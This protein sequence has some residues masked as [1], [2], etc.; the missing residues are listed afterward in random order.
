[1]LTIIEKKSLSG[2]SAGKSKDV[3]G[4]NFEERVA[5]ILCHVE[6]LEKLRNPTK[7]IVGLH[8]G[9][10]HTIT[11]ALIPNST[12]ILKIE[13][14]SDRKTIGKLPSGGNPK[15]DVLVKITIANGDI[16]T[17]TI[18]CKRTNSQVVSVHQYSAYAFSDVLNPADTD[19]RKLLSMFQETPSLS[20]FGDENIDRLTA[21]ISPY[22]KELT[23][24]VLEGVG[25]GGNPTTQ[26]STH[27][28]TYNDESDVFS[29]YTLEEYYNKL[30][31]NDIK[32]HFGTF[33]SWTYAS[34]QRGKSI[35]LKCKI[36]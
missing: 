26:W 23:F 35:Q 28:L 18:S 21:A 22:L 11:T 20:N 9:M 25:G 16:H 6:N 36:I 7:P 30:I 13:A 4:K 17:F 27:L 32:G 15:T 10:F 5:N 19:L 8:F 34:K 29:M 2:V 24:W 14:S 12:Q 1:M 3:L 31:E 33:F